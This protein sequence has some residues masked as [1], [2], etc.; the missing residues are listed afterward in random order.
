MGNTKKSDFKIALVGVEFEENLSLRYLAGSLKQS[1]FE[2][3]DIFAYNNVEQALEICKKII[4]TDYQLVGVSMV[5]QVRAIE[6]MTLIQLLRKNGYTQH[7]TVGGQFA[8]LHYNE[9]FD[10]C[11]GLNSL[12]RFEAERSVVELAGALLENK[13]L[14]QVAGLIWKDETNI[15]QINT[16]VPL[17]GDINELAWPV[18]KERRPEF[19]G[20][21]S[22]HMIGSRGCHATCKYCCVATLAAQRREASREAGYST[23]IPGTRRRTADNIANEMAHLYFKYDVRIFEFQDDNWINPKVETAVDYFKELRKELDKKGVGQIG[24]TLKMRADSVRPEILTILK[25]IGLIRVF[26]GIESGTQNLLNKLGRKTIDQGSLKALELLRQFQIPAYFNALLF[27]PDIH[28]SDIEPELQFLEKCVD[29][30]FEVVEVVIYGKTGLY[31]TLKQENRLYGNY[32][33]YDYNYMDTETQNTHFII[34]Q[35]ETRHFGVYSPAKMAADLGFNL[36]LLHVFYPG[37]YVHSIAKKVSELT[38]RINRDQLRIIRKASEMAVADTIV[39]DDIASICEETL[40]LDLCFYCELVALQKEIEDH[41]KLITQSQNSFSYYKL[42]GVVQ[43]GII[44]SLFMLMA[45]KLNSQPRTA[46]DSKIEKQ[47]LEVS[48]ISDKEWDKVT[49]KLLDGKTPVS[50]YLPGLFKKRDS[51]SRTGNTKE[52][53][54]ISL[55][56]NDRMIPLVY[57]RS[58]KDYNRLKNILTSNYPKLLISTTLSFDIDP[59]GQVVNVSS[60]NSEVSFS[61][62]IKNQIIELLKKKQFYTYEVEHFIAVPTHVAKKSKKPKKRVKR[63]KPRRRSPMD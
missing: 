12:I 60:S 49:G 31:T 21:K 58:V 54:N 36:G 15:L 46:I 11:S 45:Q 30:P 19:L 17:P 29:V 3:V 57:K 28:F 63:K 59:N 43:S 26:V 40:S 4:E 53:K 56:I 50:G 38:E 48:S 13:T 1:G 39:E 5:F 18:R 14:E 44:A 9:I 7:I 6:D 51:L 42:G 8:T 62:E 35:L 27:G 47:L 55:L 25:E 61:P 37:E 20:L 2:H 10:D 52:M 33:E 24:L 16:A 22:A 41:V 34:S 23:A 32:L